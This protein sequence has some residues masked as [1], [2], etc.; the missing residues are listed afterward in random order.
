ML[1]ELS[2][3]V[4]IP[5]GLEDDM[6]PNQFCFTYHAQCQPLQ[7]GVLQNRKFIHGV[8]K[9]VEKGEQVSDWPPW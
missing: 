4:D 1:G 2:I 9:F 3:F 6:L 8:A 7:Q 5:P